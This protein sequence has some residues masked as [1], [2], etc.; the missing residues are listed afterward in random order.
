MSA[1]REPR[2]GECWYYTDMDG[3]R[4][5]VRVREVGEN[6]LGKTVVWQGSSQKK[7]SGRDSWLGLFK[8][9]PEHLPEPTP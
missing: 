6:E 5:H 2:P 7:A 4:V 1:Q 9:C 3:L 8:P